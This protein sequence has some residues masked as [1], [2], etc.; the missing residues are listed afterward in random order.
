MRDLQGWDPREQDMQAVVGIH[1]TVNERAWRE[2]LAWESLHAPAECGM[3]RLR[4]FVGRPRDYSPR[5]RL[6]NLLVRCC[7]PRFV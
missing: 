4:R 6:L 7:C 2:V 5:A 1:N 3:P